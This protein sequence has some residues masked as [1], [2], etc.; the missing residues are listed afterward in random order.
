VALVIIT[1]TSRIF[2]KSLTVRSLA[3]M[4]R[5]HFFL[6]SKLD[7]TIR[8]EFFRKYIAFSEEIEVI[9]SYREGQEKSLHAKVEKK[10]TTTI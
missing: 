8:H 1:S 4:G 3:W 5:P 2:R 10:H 6:D 9:H 7:S